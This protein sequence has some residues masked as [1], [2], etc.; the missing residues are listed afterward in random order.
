MLE[1][2]VT[3]KENMEVGEYKQYNL[4]RSAGISRFVPMSKLKIRRKKKKI[5]LI[6][7][8]DTCKIKNKKKPSPF[9]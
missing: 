2:S 6:E 4:L 7:N 5:E 8:K 1:F 9:G 3:D